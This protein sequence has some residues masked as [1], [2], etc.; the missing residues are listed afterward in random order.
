MERMKHRTR[1]VLHK[2]NEV[3]MSP[4]NN[5]FYIMCSGV[6]EEEFQEWSTSKIASDVHG[7]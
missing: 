7:S 5:C 1:A 2:V 6:I 3:W 4:S